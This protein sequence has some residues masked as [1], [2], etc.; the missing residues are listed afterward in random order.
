MAVQF[1]HAWTETK[2]AHFVCLPVVALSMKQ[3]LG[4]T[5]QGRNG[6]VAI[7]A[8]LCVIQGYEEGC[9]L[10]GIQRLL[11]LPSAEVSVTSIG[12]RGPGGQ[13]KAENEER[14]LGWSVFL[15]LIYFTLI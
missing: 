6:V 3:T 14:V 1:V 5:G 4:V 13:I 7:V 2:Y 9:L 15:Q 8:L 10:N 12:P 11:V